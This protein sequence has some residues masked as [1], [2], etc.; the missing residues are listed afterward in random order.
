[1]YNKAENGKN[2]NKVQ[3]RPQKNIRPSLLSCCGNAT[4]RCWE[5]FLESIQFPI[6][7]KGVAY[8]IK[9]IK[10]YCSCKHTSMLIKI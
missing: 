7:K 5:N 10:L 4:L 8:N 3:N 9:I 1:M 2:P 6:L